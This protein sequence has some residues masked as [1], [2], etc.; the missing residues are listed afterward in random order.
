MSKHYELIDE[1]INHKGRTLY[2]IR[3]TRELPEQIVKAGDLGGFVE[4]MDNLSDTAWV[5]DEAMVY[6]DAQVFDNA[7]VAEEKHIMIGTFCTTRQFNWT[8]QRTTDGH[9]L[10]IGCMSG[11]LDDHQILCDSDTWIETTDPEIIREARPEYQ[12]VI[13]LCRAR[14]ARWNK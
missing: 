3:A 14:V 9:V 4:S 2:R 5:A 10:H 1:T 8:L 11:T 7:R 12:Y 13:D 6:G